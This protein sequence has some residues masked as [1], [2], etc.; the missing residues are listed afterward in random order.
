M[1]KKNGYILIVFGIVLTIISSVFLLIQYQEQKK[2]LHV[3]GKLVNIDIERT[4]K[5]GYQWC[6]IYEGKVN[7]KTL[8]LY[9]DTKNSKN[10]IK[11]SQIFVIDESNPDDYK[12]ATSIFTIFKGLPFLLFS[13]GGVV[14]L[15]LVEEEELEEKNR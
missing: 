7:G 8:E 13:V 12:E 3:E 4:E 1:N 5:S 14:I 6:G 15:K 9:S 2:L 11:D 10:K